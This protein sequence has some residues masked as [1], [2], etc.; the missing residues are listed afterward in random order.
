MGPLLFNYALRGVALGFFP[1]LSGQPNPLI[2]P[3]GYVAISIIS[4]ILLYY[5]FRGKLHA[6]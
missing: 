6:A 4:A 5:G 2:M 1:V 3:Y